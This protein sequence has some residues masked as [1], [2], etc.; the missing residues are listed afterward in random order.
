M[1][2]YRE[3]GLITWDGQR[4]KAVCVEHVCIAPMAKNSILPVCA[5][6]PAWRFLL[7]H[8]R[9][10][11]WWLIDVPSVFQQCSNP[12]LVDDYC[13]FY[14][15]NLPNI[16]GIITIHSRR[17]S[18]QKKMRQMSTLWTFWTFAS[19][20]T[21]LVVPLPLWAATSDDPSRRRQLWRLRSKRVP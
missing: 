17:L 18:A 13:F 21:A 8:A 5:N 3:L 1:A 16:F 19:L 10:S 6:G 9:I 11:G 14:Y 12:L 4:P 15:P 20:E 2:L 7:D